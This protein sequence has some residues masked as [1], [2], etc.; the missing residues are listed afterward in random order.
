[1]MSAFMRKEV[2]NYIEA[3]FSNISVDWFSCTKIGPIDEDS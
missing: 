2:H 3:V 1:M